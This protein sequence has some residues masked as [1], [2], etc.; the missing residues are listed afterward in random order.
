[1]RRILLIICIMIPW[2]LVTAQNQQ[3]PYLINVSFGFG[4]NYGGIGLKTV[5]GYKNSG[6]LIG[7]GYNSVDFAYEIGGQFSLG[8]WYINAGYAPMGGGYDEIT[9][10]GRSIYGANITTGVNFAF[11]KER[12]LF[13]DL[14]VGYSWGGTVPELYERLDGFNWVIGLGYRL[15]E[16]KQ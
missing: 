4:P 14:G 5:I 8:P 1:M 2:N 10:K 13:S 7:T 9:S 15:I 3:N 16:L 11:G 12:R 6:L